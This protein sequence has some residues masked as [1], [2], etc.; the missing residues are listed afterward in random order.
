MHKIEKIG[1]NILYIKATR[2]LDANEAEKFVKKFEKIIN[3]MENFSVL[4]DL[5]DT[6][7]LRVEAIDIL[8]E[9]LRKNN[10]KLSKSSFA[11]CC[12]PILSKEFEILIKRA[13]SEDRKIVGSLDEAKE[14]L[15]IKEINI[16]KD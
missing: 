9:L 2:I 10:T 8:L 6:T 4:I 7:A 11:I 13:E 14:W 16:Q 1:E 15:G 12:N 5:L 3:N